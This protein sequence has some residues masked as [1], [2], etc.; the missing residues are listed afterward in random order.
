[1]EVDASAS[2]A[3]GGGRDGEVDWTVDWIEGLPENRGGGVAENGAGVTCE[4]RCHKAPWRLK[5]LCPTA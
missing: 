2:L 1:M 4:N 3:A 5:P